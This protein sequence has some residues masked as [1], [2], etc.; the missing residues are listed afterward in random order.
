M[1]ILK[2]KEMIGGQSNQHVEERERET[3]RDRERE[4]DAGAERYCGSIAVL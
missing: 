4:R 2:T 1:M 3:E